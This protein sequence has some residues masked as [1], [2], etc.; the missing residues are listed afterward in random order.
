M[1]NWLNI[2]VGGL[3]VVSGFALA[4]G[5]IESGQSMTCL[6]GGSLTLAPVAWT[7]ASH[8]VTDTWNPAG[9]GS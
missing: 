6:L 1:S 5:S 9:A 7:I 2:I 4:A 8:F 3:K